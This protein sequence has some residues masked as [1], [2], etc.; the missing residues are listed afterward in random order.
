[1]KKITSEPGS[2]LL[3][4]L[5]TSQ[6]VG[7]FRSLAVS[8]AAA[9]RERALSVPS[10]SPTAGENPTLDS[11]Y[12]S[13]SAREPPPAWRLSLLATPLPSRCEPVIYCPPYGRV[14]LPLR[15]LLPERDPDSS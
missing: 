12:Y 14:P 8:A 6:R 4:L 2:R 9:T 15:L 7:Y 3:L 5:T 11:Y 1:M 10:R 13:Q